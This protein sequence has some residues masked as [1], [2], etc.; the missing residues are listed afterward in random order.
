M[1]V[2][3]IKVDVGNVYPPIPIR[4]IV[5]NHDGDP[6]YDFPI[7]KSSQRDIIVRPGRHTIIFFGMNQLEDQTEI[8][9]GGDYRCEDN[10]RVE[11]DRKYASVFKCVIT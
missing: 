11:A 2:I 4:V 9:L 8:T 10:H 6:D 7:E 5:Q 1:G 3:T